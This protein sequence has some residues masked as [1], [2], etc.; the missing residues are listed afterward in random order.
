[1]KRL[2]IFALFILV[3][4]ACKKEKQIEK[5]LASK[6]GVWN[7]DNYE[8]KQ[9]STYASDNY[10]VNRA[11]L[12]TVTFKDNSTGLFTIYDEDD[13][14]SNTDGFTYSNTDK[15]LTLNMEDGSLA[16]TYDIISW[17]KNRLT[18]SKTHNYKA[19]APGESGYLGT[20]Y[21]KITIILSK[22]K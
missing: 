19:A 8:G 16:G 11:N 9:E 4:T 6:G 13:G 17:K 1:M 2:M 10:Y 15:T 21:E 7:I 20:G 12:G 18:I 3:L 14:S 5:N 22:K